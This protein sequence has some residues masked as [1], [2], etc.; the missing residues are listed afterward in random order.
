M[1]R[2]LPAVS[3]CSAI[4]LMKGWE[5]SQG[6]DMELKHAIEQKK[7]IYCAETFRKMDWRPIR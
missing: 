2:D 6:A 7:E 4:A 5:N 1:K 3:S